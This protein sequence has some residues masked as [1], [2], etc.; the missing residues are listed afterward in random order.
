MAEP[1]V[2]ADKKAGNSPFGILPEWDLTDL[3]AAPDA[4]EIDRD[5][6]WLE[7][8]CAKFAADYQG[9]LA[10]LDADGMLR[11]VQRDEEISGV[12]GRIMSFA[13]LRYYQLTTDAERGKFL[14]DCQ[15]K[16]TTYST[17]LVFW[18]LELNRLDEDH[19]ERLLQAN[20]DLGRYRPIFD[21]IR[22]MKPY[23]LSDVL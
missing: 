8:A 2:D 3:Y 9:K 10:T 19:L 16:I 14:S 18:S 17:Q 20:S 6:A 7:Q 12:A 1:V 5:L 11:A 15:D 21:R 23:Q 13:G 4:P 22:A